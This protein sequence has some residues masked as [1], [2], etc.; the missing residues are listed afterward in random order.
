MSFVRPLS[1]PLGSFFGWT[2]AAIIAAGV[3]VSPSNLVAATIT[4]KAGTA[5][6]NRKQSWVGNKVPG[7]ADIALWDATV[8]TANTVG[9]GGNVS[10]LGLRITNPGGLVTITNGFT[11]TLGSA[12]ID[13]STATQNL[14][15]NCALVLGANQTW[16]ITSGR[17]LLTA[18]V[19]SGTG[20][21]TKNGLGTVTLS[22]T[23]TFTGG[24]TINAGTL[25]VSNASGLGSGTG[26]LTIN[27]TGI[28]Q[29]TGTFSSART[30]TL[31]GTGGASSGGTFDVTAANNETRTGVISGTGSLIKSG[32][33]I[34][35]LSAVNT[36][37]GD[38]FINGGT[39]SIG[40]SQA[41]GAL[42]PSLGSSLYAVHMASGTTLQTTFSTTGDNRQLQLSGGT[43]TLDVAT[44]TTQQ[45]NGL[46]Y[47]S[48]GLVKTGAGTEILTNANTYTGGTTINGGVL[49]VN[50]SSG[51]ATGT[52]AVTVNS[53]TTLSGL[54][55][56]TGFSGA[57]TIS[58]AV[59]VNTGGIL[60]SRSGV[61]LTLGGL[62]LNAG[63]ASNFQI[64]APTAAAIINI[65]G[66]NAF[67]LAGLSTLTVA[68]AGG[69]AA[70][71]YHLFDYTGTALASIA[72]LQLGSTP[73]GGFTY[74][75]S[76]NQ[77]NTSIDLIVSASNDQWA[78]DTNGNWNVNSNWTSGI[79]PNA[80]AAQANF[81]GLIQQARTVSVNGAYT[82]GTMTFNNANSYTIATD[83]VAGH[84]LTLNNNGL[85]SITVL[86]GNHTISAPLTLADNLEITATAGTAV[87]I[88]GT[89]GES[90]AGRTVLLDGAGTVTFGGTSANTFTGLTKVTAGTLNLNK[91]AG[92][93]AITTGGLQVDSGATASWLASNQITDTASITAN[94]M[95]AL[96]TFSETI[97]SLTGSGSVTIGSGGVLTIGAS[98]N[99]SSTFAGVISGSGTITKSGTGTLELTGPNTFGGVGQTVTVNSGT[100]SISSDGNLGNTSNSVTFN[101]GTLLLADDVTSARSIVLAAGTIFDS[102]NNDGVFNGAISG[103]GGLTKNGA[104]IV[105]LFGTNN[106]SGGTTINSGTVAVNNASSLGSASGNLTLN[107]GTLEVTTGFSSTRNIVLGSASSTI[108]VDASQTYSTSGV[109]SGTGS[110]TKTDTGTL[111][112]TGTNTFTGSTTVDGG[113]LTAAAGS[114]NAALGTTTSITVNSGGTLLLGA[115]NQINN[116][117]P[118]ILD[119]GTLARGN[120]SEGA[121]NAVGAGTL[122]LTSAGSHIDFGTG[123]VGVLSFANF[124]PSVDLLT[125]IIDNWT[126]S[127]STQGGAGTDRLIFNS[128]QAANLALFQFTGYEPGAVQFNLNGG[129]YEITPA[130]VPETSTWLAACL[131]LAAVGFQQRSRIC[132][133]VTLRRRAFRFSNKEMR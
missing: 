86:A 77:T 89:I 59:T 6:L 60:L 62:T 73:G 18:G 67:S 119:G 123:T 109:L 97:G 108:Q 130:V 20:G 75:L 42:P 71:T 121:S 23:N 122:T 90:S 43:A 68:N 30:I 102:N 95:V 79:F 99:L 100:L 103:A 105:S 92:V 120:F 12:G 63:A 26:A 84:G 81:L 104:G 131:A 41:L 64:G 74:S 133:L 101:G 85:A 115:S 72:N 51:S 126:G 129:F 65:T 15:L 111:T 39:L 78:N 8:T 25:S 53:G 110:L 57:G 61:T 33:G 32:T 48:G 76:N 114:G 9:L 107:A 46:V 70:G 116:S 87:T 3:F 16:D 14:T 10:W 11:L 132:R 112:L 69:L 96:G 13:M 1:R 2:V 106:Y 83:S 117:A 56:A 47:G 21:L 55:T 118:V 94:G 4:K 49:Q 52:G 124:D 93:N 35:T 91:T 58:G 125:I 24:V 66:T 40:N 54:P 38:T 19:V 37:T 5:N 50:N 44:A 29:A 34:L 128:S 82:I 98:N 17:T 27:P 88:S 45:R 127:A 31:G 36:Y 28:L 22:G 80:I 113:T 7:A